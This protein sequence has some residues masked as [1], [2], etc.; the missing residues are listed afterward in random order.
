MKIANIEVNALTITDKVAIES[1]KK[2]WQKYSI[3]QLIFSSIIPMLIFLLAI[4]TVKTVEQGLIE[5]YGCLMFC[6]MSISL[7]IV[8]KVAEIYATKLTHE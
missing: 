6:L 7:G 4:V 3:S 2:A 5:L 1:N 8:F